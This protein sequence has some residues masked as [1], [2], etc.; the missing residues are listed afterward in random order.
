MLLYTKAKELLKEGGFNL[1]KFATNSSKLQREVDS[2]EPTGSSDAPDEHHELDETYLE[3]QETLAGRTEGAWNPVECGIRRLGDQPQ[4]NSSSGQ[5]PRP[6]EEKHC[7][8]G[9]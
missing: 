5:G 1:R 8:S 7:Q 4:W 3:S 9:G 6:Y 2:K